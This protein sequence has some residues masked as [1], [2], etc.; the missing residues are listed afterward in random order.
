YQGGETLEIEIMRDRKRQT[1]SVEMPDNRQSAAGEVRF[2]LPMMIESDAVEVVDS[3][4]LVAAFRHHRRVV[5]R[6]NGSLRSA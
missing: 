5:L 1:V 3:Q 2:S 4:Y 6:C